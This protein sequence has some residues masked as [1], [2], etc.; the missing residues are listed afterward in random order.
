MLYKIARKLTTTYLDGLSFADRTGGLVRVMSDARGKKD[1]LR[2]YPCEVN[3]DKVLGDNQYMRKL[4]P[5]SDKKSIMYWELGSAPVVVEDHNAYDIYE[6]GLKL[7]CWFNY[8]KVDPDMYDPAFLIAEIKQAIPFKIGSFDCL[9]VVTCNCTGEDGNKGEIFSPYTYHEPES[10]FYKYPYDY[11]VLNFDISY[12]VVR[13]CYEEGL[14][15]LPVDPILI[16]M[17]SAENK[18]ISIAGVSG[19]EYQMEV[20]G[21]GDVS[22]LAKALYE[23]SGETQTYVFHN[24]VVANSFFKIDYGREYI[25]KIVAT[26]Q[27]IINI[28]IPND[29]NIRLEHINLSGNDISIE[30]YLIALILHLYNTDVNNGFLDIRG[31][32]N[33]VITDGVTLAYIAAMEAN[34]NWVIEHN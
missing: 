9:T 12:R 5:D 32:T 26:R 1:T 2:T 20:Y 28:T 6:A 4:I 11:F 15:A 3:Q 30:A 19:R 8:Q 16:T 29:D 24:A 34:R 13:N 10:Q 22:I 25:R 23:F 17:K 33:A 31:G 14:S 18:S 7:V 27:A 21:T